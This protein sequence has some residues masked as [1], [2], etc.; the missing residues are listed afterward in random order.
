[1][2][3]EQKNR[4]AY[5]R[6]KYRIKNIKNTTPTIRL[7]STKKLVAWKTNIIIKYIKKNIPV[8]DM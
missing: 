5:K 6:L 8:V 7:L 2:R 1:M 4:K 3:E